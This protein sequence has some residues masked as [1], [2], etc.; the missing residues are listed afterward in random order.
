MPF[1][2]IK[3]LYMSEPKNMGKFHPDL[4]SDWD[5]V[6]NTDIDPMRVST[7]ALNAAS[8]SSVQPARTNTVFRSLSALR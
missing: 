5:Y 2:E 8:I 4:L 6:N 1:V 3:E 7:V